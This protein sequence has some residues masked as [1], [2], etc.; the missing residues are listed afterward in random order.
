MPFSVDQFFD[1][2]AQYNVGVWPA[3]WVL[4][5][6][7][8]LVVVLLVQ[9]RPSHGHWISAA[10]AVLWGWVAVAYHF[11]YFTRINSAAWAFGAVSLLGCLWF[12][13]VGV[14]QRRLHFA[15]DR[16]VQAWAAGMLIT[17]AL[18]IYPWVG[19]VSGHRYPA[20][21]TFGLP[22]PTTIFTIGVLLLARPPL[23]RS[24]F[25]VPLLWT[26]VGSSAAFTLGV[27]QDLGLL[28]AC[29]AAL[30]ALT[31]RRSSSL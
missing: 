24:V 6:L 20:A 31:R 28:V 2:F 23:V 25:I 30:V 8:I 15:L 9:G 4:N 22:C 16:G 17:F 10:L 21:P 29:A 14:V 26:L 5:A 11:A 18:V 3:Q 13:W 27:Y 12:V 1:V 7:A 19:Y